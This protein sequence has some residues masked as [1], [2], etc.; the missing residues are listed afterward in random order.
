MTRTKDLK[1]VAL[2]LA[3]V[4]EELDELLRKQR[5][6]PGNRLPDLLVLLEDIARSDA[7]RT[8]TLVRLVKTLSRFG[9]VFS[10][11]LVTD[12]PPVTQSSTGELPTPADP[13]PDQAE[14]DIDTIARTCK[15]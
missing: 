11:S 12:G 7:D 1:A 6:S 2:S 5:R 4:A 14:F 3:S 10:E 9:D 8:D 15:A 13:D